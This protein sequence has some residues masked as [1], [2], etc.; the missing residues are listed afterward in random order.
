V[1]GAGSLGLALAARLARAGARV[2]LLTRRPEA[3]CLLAQR[4]LT[5]EDP[6]S[7]ALTGFA[8]AASSEPA[9]IDCSAGPFFLCTR[10]DAVAE[11]ARAFAGRI[12]ALVTFQN[13]VMSE[14]VAA[15]FVPRVIGGVWRETVTRL[16][17]D[18]VRCQLDRPGR[19]IVGLHPEGCNAGVEAVAALLRS[20]GVDVSVSASI[21]S[22]KWLKLCV[23]L[24][25][26]PNALVRR[27]DHSTAEF[28]EVKVRLL[29]EARSVLAAAG[30]DITPC[31]GRDRTLDAEIQFQREALARGTS[32]R[33]IPLYNQVWTSL[34][35]ATPLEADAYHERILA[36]ASTHG[37]PAPVNALV[38]A[39]LLEAARR[40]LGPE[41][42]T[43]RELLPL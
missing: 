18:R 17:D 34:R 11:L 41:C 13:D 10:V 36:L 33:S 22:D 24:M 21:G 40:S 16:A 26:T 28:V 12:P 37:V 7:G 19:A 2:Q 39:R 23:N 6:A 20:A 4:G 27:P 8:V 42:F 29:E 15:R 43:A 30:I 14:E 3:A 1:V 5:V 25:S 9:L 31:D 35:F 32:A 38:L